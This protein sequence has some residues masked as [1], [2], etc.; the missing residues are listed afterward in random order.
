MMGRST[1]RG[2]L[3]AASILCAGLTLGLVFTFFP[4]A[5]TSDL[6][7]IVRKNPQMTE[8]L[9]GCA[10]GMRVSEGFD[11]SEKEAFCVC[12]TQEALTMLEPVDIEYLVAQQVGGHT[13][14]KASMERLTEAQKAAVYSRVEKFVS[15]ALPRCMR[16]AFTGP[17]AVEIVD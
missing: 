3:I 7:E 6:P 8:F 4:T 15:A 14:V 1:N 16:Q 10:D 11:A 13:G 5:E 12:Y 9:Q 2:L 17:N